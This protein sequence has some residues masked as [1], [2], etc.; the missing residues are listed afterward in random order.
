MS[1]KVAMDSRD[2]VPTHAVA[3][4]NSRNTV[5]THSSEALAACTRR[6]V[7][8][9]PTHSGAGQKGTDGGESSK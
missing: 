4:A 8:V 1:E 6:T 7:A 3:L 5:S 9:H 2:T